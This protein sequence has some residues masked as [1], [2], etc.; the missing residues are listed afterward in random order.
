M[1]FCKQKFEIEEQ[2]SKIDEQ[3]NAKMQDLGSFIAKT[4]I[5]VN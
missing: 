1:K 3:I 5:M 2:I 4:K